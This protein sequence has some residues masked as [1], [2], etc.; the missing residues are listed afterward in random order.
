MKTV[1]T[2][3]LSIGL[4]MSSGCLLTG[5]SLIDSH[6]KQMDV[7]N[8]MAA[9]ASE[10]LASGAITSVHASGQGLNPGITVEAAIVYRASARY[11][12]L[13]GQF[14]I[15]QSGKSESLGP[16]SKAM[17]EAIY[18]D[19]STRAGEVRRAIIDAAKPSN[20]ESLDHVASSQPNP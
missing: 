8:G 20:N 9:K 14:S 5:C 11:D 3:L 12:G 17:I 15:A 13:A 16:E 10:S 6:A 1:A 4:T 7:L 18:R 19:A 2:M